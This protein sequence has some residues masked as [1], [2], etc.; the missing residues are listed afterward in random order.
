MKLYI[1]IWWSLIV[2][3]SLLLGTVGTNIA[4]AGSSSAGGSVAGIPI[5]ATKEIAQ[6]QY[7]WRAGFESKTLSGTYISVIGRTWW[8]A[9]A[10]CESTG[11]WTNSFQYGGQ[12]EYNSLYWRQIS[13]Y[14]GSCAPGRERLENLGGHDF[15][16]NGQYSSPWPV[17]V[18]RSE[19]H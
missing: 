9:R 5:L 4:Q 8:T 10:F 16:H 11:L 1:K 2:T 3:T 17:T 14:Y 13:L 15:Q 19:Y 6:T 7:T 18:S 12:V